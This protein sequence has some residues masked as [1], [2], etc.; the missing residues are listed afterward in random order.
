MSRQ[1]DSSHD[2]NNNT[3][4]HNLHKSFDSDNDY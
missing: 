1:E 4:H 2:R 3:Y